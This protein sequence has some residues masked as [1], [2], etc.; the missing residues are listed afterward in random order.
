MRKPD[1]RK[2]A[3]FP[4]AAPEEIRKQASGTAKDDTPESAKQAHGMSGAPGT[5][6]GNS[7][8]SGSDPG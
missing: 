8:V 1:S 3:S 7:S 5:H 4:R 6:S 2:T